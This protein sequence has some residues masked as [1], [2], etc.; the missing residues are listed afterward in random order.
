MDIF[1][2]LGRLL[3]GNYQEV[4]T[5][6]VLEEIHRLKLRATDSKA[7]AFDLAISMTTKCRILDE[8][9]RPGEDV[10]DQLIRL[11]MRDDY[12]VA[13][14]DA[15]LRRRLRAMGITVIFLRQRSHLQIDGPIH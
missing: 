4:I 11:A 13:T 9:L 5:T 12:M 1:S 6:S 8:P 3:E 7:K 10:D 15:D 14:T 2:E